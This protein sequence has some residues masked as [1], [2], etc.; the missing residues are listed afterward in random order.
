MLNA[1]KKSSSYTQLFKQLSEAASDV[2]AAVSE[3]LSNR[4]NWKFSFDKKNSQK[5]FTFLI[6]AGCLGVTEALRY[7]QAFIYNGPNNTT[8]LLD[9]TV[10]GE[11]KFYFQALL[12]VVPYFISDCNMTTRNSNEGDFYTLIAGVKATQGYSSD[13]STHTV[14]YDAQLNMIG[15]QS[16]P[17]GIFPCTQPKLKTAVSGTDYSGLKTMGIVGGVAIASAITAVGGMLGF[18]YCVS[19]CEK[20]I[21]QQPLLPLENNNQPDTAPATSYQR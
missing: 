5:F 6:G 8:R 21:E 10:T 19:K 12:D 18:F 16:V 13:P 2:Y 4:S 3:S 11:S 7:Q 20:P 17:A 9:F 14:L 1:I 15:F